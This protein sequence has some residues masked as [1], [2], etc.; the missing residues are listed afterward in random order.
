MAME[1]ID[2][3]EACNYE[4][5]LYTKLVLK[6]YPLELI[7]INITC[8]SLVVLRQRTIWHLFF[9]PQWLS[10]Q[11][12]W[13]RGGKIFLYPLI[14]SACGLQIKLTKDRLTGESVYWAWT[15]CHRTN[16]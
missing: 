11:Y 16:K 1:K 7:T 4:N 15:C 5:V 6:L 12:H 10:M 3:M 14:V 8:S 2:Q 9:F 13:Y